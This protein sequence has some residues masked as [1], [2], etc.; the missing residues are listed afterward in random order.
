MS[1]IVEIKNMYKSFFGVI[2]MDG[3]DFSLKEGEVHC[4]IGENGCGKSSMIKVISGFYPYDRGELV[5]NGKAY[6]KINPSE[7]MKEGIQVIY[8]DFSLFP[9]MTIAENIMMYENTGSR[10]VFVNWKNQFKRAE[11][12]LARIKFDID[13]RQYVY[14]LNIAQMQMVAICRALVQRARLIIMDEPTTALTTQEVGKLFDVVKDLKAQGISILFVSH[15]LDEILHISD[16]ITVMRNGKNVFSSKEGEKLPSKED[17][18]L[19]MTGKRFVKDVRLAEIPKN[20]VP[21]LETKSISLHG[22]F[23]NISFSLYAGEILGITGLLGCGRQELA[24]TL[25]GTARAHSG[26]LQINGNQVKLF[27]SVQDA[28]KHD[29]AYVPED[30]LTK[31]LHMDQSI[32]DNAVARIIESFQKKSGLLSIRRL[33]KGKDTA[34]TSVYIS[35]LRPLNPV[36]SLSGGNQQKVCLIKWLASNPRILVLNAPTV[37]VDVGAK[38]DIHNIVKKLADN[39]IGVIIISDDIPEIMQLCSRVLVMR[40]GSIAQEVHVVDTTLEMLEAK[41]AEDAPLQEESA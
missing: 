25:F 33:Q 18:I 7:S 39:G 21:L 24:E 13:P 36:R 37:G 17:L 5:I 28:L 14:E 8:Q 40:K 9:N 31:G 10:K 29:I 4:L 38:A 3:M 16:T 41:L 15:K 6:R 30:R 32:E 12:V 26:T 20:A 19:H 35:G 34:L 27:R 23:E 22:A 1:K 11:E 2:A